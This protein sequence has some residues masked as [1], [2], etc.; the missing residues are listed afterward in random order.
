MIGAIDIGFATI[1]ASV[2]TLCGVVFAAI[3]SRA[4]AKR[5]KTTNGRTQAQIIEALDKKVDA[6][7]ETQDTM[8]L[9]MQEHTRAH[10]NERLWS[11]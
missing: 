10:E 1:T 3:Y 2:V 11:P 8:L 5:S 4:A 7:K 6:V 9:W